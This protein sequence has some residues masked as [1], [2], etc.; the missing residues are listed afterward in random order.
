MSS[1]S[2][3]IMFCRSHID[4]VVHDGNRIVWKLPLKPPHTDGS[5]NVTSKIANDIFPPQHCVR[6]QQ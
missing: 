4:A 6:T 2:L 1:T 3:Y 5:N